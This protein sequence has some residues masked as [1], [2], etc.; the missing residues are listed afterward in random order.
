MIALLLVDDEPALLEVARLF[1]E[2]SGEIAVTS[3]ESPDRAFA[4]LKETHFDVI[5]S[6]YEMPG[7]NGIDLL[8]TLR[9]A[10]NTIPF[11]IFTGKGRE[12]IVIEALNQGA[13]FYL[14]KGGDPRSQ[15]AEL[16]HKVKRAIAQQRSEQALRQSEERFRLL[17]ENGTDMISCHTLDGIYQYVS[18]ACVHLLGYQPEDLIDHPAFEFIHPE[19]TLKIR[20]CS[21]K[22]LAGSAPSHITYRIRR[23]DGGYCWIESTYR[24]VESPEQRQE[25]QVSSRDIS[26]RRIVEE[27]ALFQAELLDHIDQAVVVTDLDGTIVSWNRG[28]E[29]LFGWREDQVKGR[30]RDALFAVHADPITMERILQAIQQG[31]NWSEVAPIR[32]SDDQVIPVRMNW[33]PIHNQDRQRIGSVSVSEESTLPTKREQDSNRTIA[34]QSEENYRSIVENAGHLILSLDKQ[35]M[36][37]H[38]NRQTGRYLGY[39]PE[40]LVGRPL[41]SIL[42]AENGE[43]TGGW[44]PE[45]TS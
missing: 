11:I 25:I 36:I 24:L 21:E 10:G 30:Q 7:M 12:Q 5:V 16:G 2:R 8:K 18:P 43:G 31:E 38:C 45:I 41:P 35:G 6:D 32:R 27:Q 22:V 39:T 33:W 4:L 34:H 44:I 13:D 37:T 40:E 14:Q 1:L 15:F 42:S 26:E 17:A 23:K 20:E 29:V 3:A 28:A 9:S 19:E